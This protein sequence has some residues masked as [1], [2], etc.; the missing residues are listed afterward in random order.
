MAGILARLGDDVGNRGFVV[1][2]KNLAQQRI[3]LGEFLDRAFDHLFLDLGRLAAFGCLF[4]S[5]LALALDRLGIETLGVERL[6]EGRGNV[7]RQLLAKRFE[8]IGTRFALECDQH[9]DLAEVGRDRIVHI[10]HDHARGDRYC[11][12]PANLLVLADGGYIVGEL[13]AHGSAIGVVEV[14]QSF[15]VIARCLER[16]FGDLADEILEPVVLGDE[17]GLGVDLDRNPGG[18]L[19]GDAD[20]ALGRG[21]AGLLLRGGQAL[22]AQRVDRALEVAVAFDERLLGIHHARAGALAQRLDV[23]GGEIRHGEILLKMMCGAGPR[24][25]RTGA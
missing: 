24:F 25:S 2:Y 14:L 18:A 8:H 1:H 17:I 4:G 6:R 21:A 7:H 5:D 15:D 19:D 16:G 13:V 11:L 10:G 23:G 3:F 12:H 9:A 20:Q 22:G